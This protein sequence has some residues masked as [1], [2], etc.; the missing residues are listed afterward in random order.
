MKIRK[1]IKADYGIVDKMMQNLHT[2]HVKGCPTEHR[3]VA[4]IYSE[5]DY[6]DLLQNENNFCL[7]AEEQEHIVGFCIVERKQVKNPCMIPQKIGYMES[8][9]LC[10]Q[11]RHKGFGKEFFQAIEKKLYAEGLQSLRLTVWDFNKEAIIFYEEMGMVPQRHMYT[12]KIA[13]YQSSIL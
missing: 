1:M 4:H 13:A 6:T 9:Y 5:K 8:L 12:K 3:K 11:Y 10:P 7:I 2:L